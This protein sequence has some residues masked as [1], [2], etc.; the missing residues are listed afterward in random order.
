MIKSFKGFESL[1]A[2]RRN[3]LFCSKEERGCPEGNGENP[4]TRVWAGQWCCLLSGGFAGG[5]LSQLCLS[6]HS[7]SVLFGQLPDAAKPEA[8]REI[9]EKL[10]FLSLCFS[11]VPGF[12]KMIAPEGSLVFHEKAWNAYPYCRTGRFIYRNK[13]DSFTLGR[14]KFLFFFFSNV[15]ETLLM[16]LFSFFFCIILQ[17]WRWVAF[18]F[19]TFEAWLDQKVKKSR[20]K[21]EKKWLCCMRM[22]GFSTLSRLACAAACCQRQHA[23]CRLE[24]DASCAASRGLLQSKLLLR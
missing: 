1:S 4:L 3:Y 5:N 11:K 9:R 19:Q 8:S 24:I 12:V 13:F 6:L 20:C 16:L 17:L 10:S 18:L 15:L 7:S 22:F 23:L 14:L 21:N 2:H